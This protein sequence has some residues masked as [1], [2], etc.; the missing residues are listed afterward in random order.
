VTVICVFVD[1]PHLDT[2]DEDV[3][4]HLA[5]GTSTHDL[6]AMFG[7]VKFV[8]VGGSS[9]RMK[10]FARFMAAELGLPDAEADP[11]NICAGT[12]RYAMYKAGPVLSVSHG[13]GVPSIC[14]VLHE[15][16]KLLHHARCTDVTV[17]R[18]GTSGG[19]GL[20][21]GTVVV[22]QQAV[23]GAFQPRFEQMILGRPVV[24][25]TELDGGLVA[26]LLLCGRELSQFE[27]VAGNTMCT[28]DFYEGQARLDGAFCCFSER[29]KQE[30]LARA[31]EAG[32]RNI[33][34]EALVLAA[35]CKL[36]GLQAAVVC[37]TLLDRLQGDQLSGSHELLESFQQRPQ[38]LVGL[39]IRK[40]LQASGSV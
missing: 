17:I 39:F 31:Y 19:I 15:L 6:P 1:N 13:I 14:V 20:E 29:D 8:C 16:L 30:Y 35:M 38:R 24:R 18:I 25:G 26:E 22:T 21:P 12:D 4:Y 10:A 28:M 32:V 3:L 5:L 27:T 11:P 40:R 37:V 23:D 36:G 7:D 33:E 9:R 2:L 34:M